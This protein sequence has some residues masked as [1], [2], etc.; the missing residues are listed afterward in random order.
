MALLK[1]KVSM[2]VKNDS[3]EV[4]KNHGMLVLIWG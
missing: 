4:A 3:S 1:L 2:I